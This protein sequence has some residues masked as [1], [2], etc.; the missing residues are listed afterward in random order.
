MD[1]MFEGPDSANDAIDMFLKSD[2]ML[3]ILSLL[4]S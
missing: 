1:S 4:S 3:R 2:T